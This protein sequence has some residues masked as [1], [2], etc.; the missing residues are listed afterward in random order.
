MQEQDLR[1]YSKDSLDY[2]LRGQKVKVS[3]TISSRNEEMLYAITRF[4]NA[5]NRSSIIDDA[6]T[7]YFQTAEVE[8]QVKN[9]YRNWE[10]TWK[11]RKKRKMKQSP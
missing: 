5:Q 1:P 3:V 4:G 10:R 8:C 2:V 9:S 6:L 7:A 11:M